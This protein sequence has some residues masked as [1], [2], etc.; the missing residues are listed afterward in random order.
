MFILILEAFSKSEQKIKFIGNWNANDYGI[1]LKRKYSKYSN[2]DITDPVYDLDI[3]YSF[4]CSCKG[5][6]MDILQEGLILH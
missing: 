1:Q 3:L 2:I 5:M 6:Y 4:R